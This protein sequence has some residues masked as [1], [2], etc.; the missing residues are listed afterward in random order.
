MVP[1][2]T[3]CWWTNTWWRVIRLVE[4]CVLT[5]WS[6]LCHDSSFPVIFFRSLSFFFVQLFFA[7]DFS[8][9]SE[10]IFFVYCSL[11]FFGNFK[12][13]IFCHF[14]M[15]CLSFLPFFPCVLNTAF[16]QIANHLTEFSGIRPGDLSA[17]LSLKRLD[18]LKS[19]YVRLRYLV[20]SG[21]HFVGHG[22]HTDFRILNIRVRFVGKTPLIRAFV[23]FIHSLTEKELHWSIDWL[24][25]KE[26]RWLNDWL[27]GRKGI[28][29]ID[30]LI[31]VF[32]DFFQ[33]PA[34]QIVDT[35]QVR[36]K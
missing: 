25:E 19:V 2:R 34:S 6:R 16:L 26:S 7:F 12:F 1:W 35:V 5:L 21:V 36:V 14:Q 15:F 27:I 3:R 33:V 8:L 24:A 4:W 20:D 11:D 28:S 31:D 18:T 13:L 32:S 30:W 10:W 23:R 22:I 29:L 9:F 17:N